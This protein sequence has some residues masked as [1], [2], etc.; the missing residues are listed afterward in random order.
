MQC[1]TF[2]TKIR[3][4]TLLL[5]HVM[6]SHLLQMYEFF[7]LD[8]E[9]QFVTVSLK[10][11]KQLFTFHLNIVAKQLVVDVEDKCCVKLQSL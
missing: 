10:R 1:A 7:M 8:I 2:L 11:L 9:C 5:E 4:H 3:V 6:H